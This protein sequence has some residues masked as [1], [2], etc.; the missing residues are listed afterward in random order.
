MDIHRSMNTSGSRAK[1]SL[2]NTGFALG[3]MISAVWNPLIVKM[4]AEAGYDFV[5]IDMEHSA[6]SWEVV[7]TDCQMAAAYGVTPIV[8]LDHWHR[9]SVGKALDL[10]AQGVL[11]HDVETVAQAEEII[12]YT[13]RSKAAGRTG[14]ADGARQSLIIVVQIESA[15]GVEAVDSILRTGVADVVEIGRGDLSMSLGHPLERDHPSVLAAIDTV[16]AACKKHGVAPGMASTKLDEAEL[17]DNI[18]RGI[19]WIMFG[20]DRHI[21]I[22]GLKRGMTLFRSKA[23]VRQA[24]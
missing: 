9:D 23:N 18:D 16:V 17:S 19:R 10:G 15:A 3:T 22:H 8:R 11:F 6:V 7:A 12:S 5:Y 2:K 24:S 13:A 20:T 4:V 21:L 14:D 1:A